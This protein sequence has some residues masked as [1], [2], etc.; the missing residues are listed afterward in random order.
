MIYIN[1]P[2]RILAIRWLLVAML[3][4]GIAASPTWVAMSHASNDGLQGPAP[5]AFQSQVD[6]DSDPEAALPSLFVVFIVAW[7]VFF[8]Y[9]F[10]T[11]RR[12]REMRRDL[13][14]LR[15]VLSEMDQGSGQG[16][17]GSS[18]SQGPN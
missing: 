13:D 1:M 16:K 17:Q 12:Q 6:E 2:I 9:V 3:V 14:A 11:S 7:A 5:K 18:A 4:A 15:R 8:G 10:Y